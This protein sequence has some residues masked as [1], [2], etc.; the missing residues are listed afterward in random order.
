M[1]DA[2]GGEEPL[3]YVLRIAGE[4]AYKMES[5]LYFYQMR[6]NRYRDALEEIRN[7]AANGAVAIGAAIR[8]AE[9]A[10]KFPYDI[11]EVPK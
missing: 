1:K 2:D 7:M 11:R 6:A 3:S 4:E 10:V 5:E 8:V 9:E